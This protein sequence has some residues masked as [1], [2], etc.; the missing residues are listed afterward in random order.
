MMDGRLSSRSRLWTVGFVLLL[1]TAG[2][3]NYLDRQM[4]SILARPIQDE[5]GM[6]ER[7]YA[8]IVSLFL[9][10]YTIGNVIASAVIDRIGARYALL[11]MVGIW[12]VA[13]AL[14]GLAQDANQ[15]AFTRM[16]LGCAEI[17]GFVA[18]AVIMLE[19]FDASTR[20]HVNGICNATTMV[21][22]AISPPLVV[23][24]YLATDW[25][26]TF[27]VG[28]A[29]GILWCV[30]WLA[31]VRPR[32]EKRERHKDMRSSSIYPN[33]QMFEVARSYIL[34]ARV[35]TIVFGK[36]LVYPVW[37]FY[38]FWFPK[39]LIDERGLTLADVGAVAWI[40]YLAAAVGSVCGG[41]LSS[42]LI[43]RGMAPFKARLSSLGLAACI[44]PAGG[45]IAWEPTITVTFALASVV[46]FAQMTWQVNI[47][48]MV[49]DLLSRE[50]I[51]KVVAFA[52]VLT[53]IVGVLTTYLIGILVS[54][55]SYRPSFLVMAAAC[56][57]AFSLLF[58]LS[59]RVRLR[60]VSPASYMGS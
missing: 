49:A 14:T 27:F 3:L 56:P 55:L 34:D 48:S 2:L 26:T 52:G 10:A 31:L 19:S 60:A 30:A 8:W 17:G 50:E 18:M 46:A 38:L 6:S 1:A 16:V 58:T 23:G 21:G 12:S 11:W 43:R 9:I 42:I 35:W 4:L 20:G 36:M 7:D 53:G 44:A 47:S 40:V 15:V 24:I 32:L 45:A 59:K 37:Y 13:N 33:R 29:A 5:L 41:A 25:R 51:T 28:G 22:A 54:E 57:L 39:Y